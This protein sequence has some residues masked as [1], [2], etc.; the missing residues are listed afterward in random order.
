M[1]NNKIKNNN[2]LNRGNIYFNRVKKKKGPDP[3]CCFQHLGRKFLTYWWTFYLPFFL[4]CKSL[5]TFNSVSQ[6]IFCFCLIIIGEFQLFWSP[7]DSNY[8]DLSYFRSPAFRIFVQNIF[9]LLNTLYVTLYSTISQE[10]QNTTSSNC[11]FVR[12]HKSRLRLRLWIA[13]YNLKN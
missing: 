3:F 5:L 9:Q 11:F 12:G 1:F 7:D 10:N 8:L 2:F 13:F 4:F 6:L